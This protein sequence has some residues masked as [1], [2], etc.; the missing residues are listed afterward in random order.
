MGT[1]EKHGLFLG[2]FR[3]HGK[4]RRKAVDDR[5]R[6]FVASLGNFVPSWKVEKI[7]S[8][9]VHESREVEEFKF[10]S[11][12][13]VNELKKKRVISTGD[14]VESEYQLKGTFDNAVT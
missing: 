14:A 11:S 7:V 13:K 8:S 5:S 10:T 1:R 9:V 2:E 6:C 12:P 3:V 4:V